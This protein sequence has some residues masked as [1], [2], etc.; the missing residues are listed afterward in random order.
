MDRDIEKHQQ[1]FGTVV[2]WYFYDPENSQYDD[3]YDEGSDSGN[4]RRWKGPIT[5]PVLS[6]NRREGSN[7]TSDDG[8]YVVDTIDLRLSYEQAR[9]VGLVP[10]ISR[11]HEMHYDD[12]FIYDDRVWGIRD[13]SVTGQFEASGHDIMARVLGGQLRPDELVNDIDFARWSA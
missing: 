3:V 6:A 10:E 7:I 12:R 1:A 11:N 5:V 8:M 2:Q 13:I 4:G 9:R